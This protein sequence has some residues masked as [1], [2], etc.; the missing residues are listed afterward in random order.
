MPTPTFYIRV[1]ASDCTAQIRLNGGPAMTGGVDKPWSAAVPISEWAIDG[2]N[3][4]S[5]E[6]VELGDDPQLRAA[7]CLGDLGVAPETDSELVVIE[8]VLPDE[9][10]PP[11]PFELRGEVA[12]SHPWGR[13][14]WQ[15][16]A[17]FPTGDWLRQ[18]AFDFVSGIHGALSAGDVEPLITASTI[19][20][21]DVATCYGLSLAEVEAQMRQAWAGI[22][23]QP[24]WSLAPLDIDDF[25]FR[26][27]A[28]QRVLEPT[29]LA[30]EP[31]LRQL[32][33]VDGR[34]WNLPLLLARMNW[35]QTR[36]LAIVR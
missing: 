18:D 13:W 2:D 36:D 19:K 31:V 29:T 23:G 15:D 20:F 9:G 26:L 21:T 4:L 5:A 11:T 32:E 16:A 10:P 35:E 12:A 24:R 1:Q 7:L 34:S 33:P 27:H 3:V 8:L 14:F 17:I 25:A 6:V 30:G 28:G 22:S